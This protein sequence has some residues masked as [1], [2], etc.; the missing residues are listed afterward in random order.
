MHQAKIESHNILLNDLWHND[1][2]IFAFN[3]TWL[4]ALYFI[5]ISVQLHQNSHPVTSMADSENLNLKALGE[6]AKNDS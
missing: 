6:W 2:H 3:G 4:L 1:S 5:R